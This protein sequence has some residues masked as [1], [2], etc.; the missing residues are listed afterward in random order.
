MVITVENYL[1]CNKLHKYDV[2][3]LITKEITILDNKVTG[4]TTMLKY[5][6]R[7]TGF[8]LANMSPLLFHSRDI[9]DGHKNQYCAFV[10]AFLLANG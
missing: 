7:F 2:S 1:H 3:T 8:S 4:I 10:Y 9:W 5:L 6:K